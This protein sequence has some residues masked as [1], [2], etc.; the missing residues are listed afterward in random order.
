MGLMST[1][2][3]ALRHPWQI[4]PGR[5]VEY[6]WTRVVPLTFAESVQWDKLERTSGPL[7]IAEI[8]V[9]EFGVAGGNGLPCW[10][11]TPKR[12]SASRRCVSCTRRLPESCWRKRSQRAACGAQDC[13]DSRPAPQAAASRGME[14]HDVRDALL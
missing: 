3:K 8:A 6:V 7:G 9:I 14:R 5:V 4:H 10:S 1:V 12:W 2:A 13:G 11:A